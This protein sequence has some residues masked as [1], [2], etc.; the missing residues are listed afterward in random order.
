MFLRATGWRSFGTPPSQRCVVI[1]APHTSNWDL[2]WMLAFA[3]SFGLRPRFMMKHT[4]FVGPAGWLFRRVGGIAIER[5]RQGGVVKQ[6][7]EEFAASDSLTLV[8]PPE[9]T[10]DRTERW[11][12]GFYHIARE[13]GV[14]VALAFLDYGRREAGFGPEIEITGSVTNDMDLIRDFYADKL[15]RH[16]HLHSEIR[17]VEEDLHG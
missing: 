9:G 16:P 13:A 17:L 12:S 6:M 8:V 11:K 3:W 10:R 15:G 4:V 14:P 5:H 1:A 2:L 7:A